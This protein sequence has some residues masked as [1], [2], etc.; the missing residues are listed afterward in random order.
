MNSKLLLT[1]FAVQ[2]Y[3]L[4][5]E[6]D[7]VAGEMRA[8]GDSHAVLTWGPQAMQQPGN[9]ASPCR[10]SFPSLHP[11]PMLFILHELSA[12]MEAWD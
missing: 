7:D 6:A 4:G 8:K 3:Q 11:K 2:G 10:A 1:M 5:N 12:G 9:E